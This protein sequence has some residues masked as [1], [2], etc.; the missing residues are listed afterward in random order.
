MLRVYTI[1]KPAAEDGWGAGRTLGFGAASL[2]LLAAFVVREA[3]ARE[4]ARAAAGVPL[5][6]RRPARTSSRC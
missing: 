5:A 4:P 6:R 1:V 3:T 2:A